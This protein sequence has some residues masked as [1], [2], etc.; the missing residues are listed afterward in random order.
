MAPE[1]DVAYEKLKF[2][3]FSKLLVA[4]E[5]SG[6]AIGNGTE[7]GWSNSLK[8]LRDLAI[9][10]TEIDPAGKFIQVQ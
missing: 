8:V 5:P 2:D 9:I 3:M 1:A 6:A 10:K 4:D 7:E